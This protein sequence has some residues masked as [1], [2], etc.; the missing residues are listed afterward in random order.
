VTSLPN[1]ER[2]VYPC[3]AVVEPGE[4][5]PGKWIAHC[6]TFDVLAQADDP[7]EAL[8]LVLDATSRV[9]IDD[10]NEGLNPEDR[11]APA[12][13]WL[14]FEAVAVNGIP[15]TIES[16]RAHPVSED[17]FMAVVVAR[18]EVTCQRALAGPSLAPGMLGKKV[19]K[20]APRELR[21]A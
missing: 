16:A 17:G 8:R 13:D 7:D 12:E 20:I 21:C 5:V 15:S 4:N 9:V 18:F 6:L 14:L 19:M 2:R 3:V 10:L 11:R 1:I